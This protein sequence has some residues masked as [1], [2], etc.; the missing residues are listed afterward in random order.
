[1]REHSDCIQISEMEWRKSNGNT[2]TT[3]KKIEID[4]GHEAEQAS[5]SLG[6]AEDRQEIHAPPK[7][8]TVA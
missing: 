3:W 2:Q 7:A 4:E 1:M 6:H 5:T 8:E